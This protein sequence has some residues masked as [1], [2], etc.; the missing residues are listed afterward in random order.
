MARTA[1]PAMICG[2]MPFNAKLL[3]Q[4]LGAWDNSAELGDGESQGSGIGRA[5]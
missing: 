2:L 1:I 4:Q 5:Q 3:T